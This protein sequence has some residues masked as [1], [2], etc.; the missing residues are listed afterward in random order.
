MAT[1]MRMDALLKAK[2]RRHPELRQPLSWESLQAVCARERI[3]IAYGPLPADAVLIAGLGTSVIVLNSE[4]PPRRH[5]YRG[6]H[7]LA[8]AWLHVS[9][10]PVFHTMRDGN[11]HDPRE[12]EAEYV[13]TKLMQGW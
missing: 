1:E 6:A 11:E 13:A 9:S 2:R 7:E 5:T 4:L 10:G 3:R 12:D 8:H